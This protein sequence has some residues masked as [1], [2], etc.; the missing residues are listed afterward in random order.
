MPAVAT[1]QNEPYDTM[2]GVYD[3]MHARWLRHAG[4]EAQCAFEGAVTALLHPEMS[5][6]DAACG[7]GT[8]AR[9]M[10]NCVGGALDLTMLDA[11]A[12]MLARCRDIS[13]TRVRGRIEDLPFDPGSF[14]LVTSAWGMETSEDPEAVMQEFFRVT[15]RGGHICLVFCADRP[16][17]S[18]IGFGLRQRII[19]TGRGQFLDPTKTGAM[20]WDLGATA[21]RP[22]HCSGPAA[23][24]VIQ[25]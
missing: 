6:L 4:G 13:A 8:V 11:S 7:T 12:G 10:M 14:D 23:A 19:L 2:C 17:G 21:V 16:S 22:I 18:I 24:M 3:R 1:S 20:A 5:V 25:V 9:R 15:C